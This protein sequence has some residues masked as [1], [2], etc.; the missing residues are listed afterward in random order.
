MARILKKTNYGLDFDPI[1]ALIDDDYLTLTGI[2]KTEFDILMTFVDCCNLR[3]TI[4]RSA[5]TYLAILSIKLRCGLS[6]NL[7]ATP[8]Q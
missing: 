1:H 4:T 7:L 6:N 3:D 2:S 5:R 8:F